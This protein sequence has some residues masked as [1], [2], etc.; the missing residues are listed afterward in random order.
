M[1][2]RNYCTIDGESLSEKSSVDFVVEGQHEPV[3]T[4]HAP[5]LILM[6]EQCG[7]L[8]PFRHQVKHDMFHVAMLRAN[9]GG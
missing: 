8:V 7:A 1:S 5:D 4:H 2:Y 3:A 9:Q 6:C